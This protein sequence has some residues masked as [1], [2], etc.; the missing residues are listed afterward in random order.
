[1]NVQDSWQ[2]ITIGFQV[3]PRSKMVETCPLEI[4]QKEKS[5]V[6][7]M[8]VI[9]SLLLLKICVWLKTWNTI[10][11]IIS[12]LCDKGYKVVFYKNR[13]V[14]KNA[15]DDKILFVRN[16]C[17]NVY[18]IDIDCAFTLDKYFSALHDDG[19]LWHKRLG[20]ASMD[21]ISKISKKDLV[22]GIPKISFQKD[23][24]C[25]ACKFSKQI[26]TFFKRKKII[27]LLQNLFNYL[28]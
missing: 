1:M 9:Y 3:L 19:W 13:C 11:L 27:F 7:E 21:L 28:I 23:K 12:Q 25:E 24:I 5:L 26:K 22:E 15:C 14:I 17:V 18:T 6:S 16:R 8:L 4:T 2:G 10:L 20:H